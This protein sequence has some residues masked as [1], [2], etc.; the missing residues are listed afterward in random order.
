MRLD[1]DAAFRIDEADVTVAPRDEGAAFGRPFERVPLGLRAPL[2]VA[3]DQPHRSPSDTAA[4]VPFSNSCASSKRGGI[5]HAPRVSTKPQRPSRLADA[6]PP[7]KSPK[8]SSDG[9]STHVPSVRTA[10][11][12]TDAHAGDVAAEIPHGVERRF[13]H[14]PHLVAVAIAVAVD[15]AI[16]EQQADLPVAF[17][18]QEPV[19]TRAARPQ[20]RPLGRH[21]HVPRIVGFTSHTPQPVAC[22]K[23]ERAVAEPVAV[24]FAGIEQLGKRHAAR[25]FL[26]NEIVMQQAA[27]P[28]A[29]RPVA[30]VGRQLDLERI[31][32]AA[33][34]AEIHAVHD[35]PPQPR[36]SIAFLVDVVVRIAAVE[37]RQL[38][39]IRGKPGCAVRVAERLDRFAEMPHDRIELARER[40]I[41]AGQRIR[42]DERREPAESRKRARASLVR[43]GV[44]ASPNTR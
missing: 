31:A 41:V 11:P 8:S 1:D 36:A 42:D 9:S 20:V 2:S 28:E 44:P 18:P 30:P 22:A 29:P 25:R 6:T 27:E 15:I 24:H 40:R 16:G 19:V 26:T 23:A 35:L 43:F 38:V 39:E 37:P 12:L 21:D 5:A 32:H 13:A 3:P 34:V 10:E 14:D 4:T 33:H 7:V 17:G